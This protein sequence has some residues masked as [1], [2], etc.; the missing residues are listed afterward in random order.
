LEN[1]HI[2]R[3]KIKGATG[4]RFDTRKKRQA[5]PDQNLV[6]N[7]AFFC[8]IHRNQ[9]ARIIPAFQIEKSAAR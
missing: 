4:K 6:I 9:S 1:W 2:E 5:V 8:S 3:P 7:T